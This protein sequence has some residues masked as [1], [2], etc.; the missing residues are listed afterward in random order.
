VTS[1]RSL[2]LFTTCGSSSYQQ[3]LSLCRPARP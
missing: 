3:T 2:W 1:F